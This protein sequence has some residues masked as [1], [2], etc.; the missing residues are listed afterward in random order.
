MNMKRLGVGLGMVFILAVVFETAE[1]KSFKS[2]ESGSYV[3]QGTP[4]DTDGD[5]RT[6]N[7]V[8]LSGK[9]HVLGDITTQTVVEWSRFLPATCPNGNAGFVASLVSGG[10]VTR[11]A[12]GDLLF[13]TF[14]TGGTNCF[15]PITNSS[16]QSMSGSFTGGT[17]KFAG[18]V[19]GTLVINSTSRGL[20]SGVPPEIEFGS[21]VSHTEG[22]MPE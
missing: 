17:G 5:G 6:A 15:D 14:L 4:I 16:S 18:R 8:L 12:K 20:V 1:A 3:T 10:F 2:E 7:L 19:G 11:T 21:V 9:D 22:N 13:G